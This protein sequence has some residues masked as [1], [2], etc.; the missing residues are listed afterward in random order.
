MKFGMVFSLPP[1]VDVRH[2]WNF[3]KV[4]QEGIAQHGL[5]VG[6]I[7]DLDGVINVGNY[8][9]TSGGN[10]VRLTPKFTTIVGHCFHRKNPILK[11]FGSILA[12]S[13]TCQ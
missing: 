7:G 1:L 5:F 12:N 8:R 6:D 3:L 13:D 9:Q 10:K 2:A 11:V 4:L